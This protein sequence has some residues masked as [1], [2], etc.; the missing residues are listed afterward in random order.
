MKPRDVIADGEGGQSRLNADARDKT[1]GRPTRM[2]RVD[3]DRLRRDEDQKSLGICNHPAAYLPQHAS[4]KNPRHLLKP[5]AYL[6]TQSVE[7]ESPLLSMHAGYALSEA[8]A[9]M[10]RMSKTSSL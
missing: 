3:I 8:A 9:G 7:Q 1:S 2:A 5:A 4:E 10:C 6:S